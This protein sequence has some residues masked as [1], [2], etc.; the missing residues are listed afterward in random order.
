MPKT[1]LPIAN[2][3]YLSDSLPI[4]AQECV[5]WYPSLTEAPALS[6]ECLFGTPGLKQVATSGATNQANRGAHVMDGIPYFVNGG[7]LYRLNRTITND[8]ASYSTQAL[9][10][11][12]GTGRV[13]MADNGT[14]LC[15]VVGGTVSKGYIFTA[16]PDTLT[17]ISD[18]DFKANGEPQHVVFVDGYFA[19]TTNTKKFIIS[20]LN[21]GLQ[22]NALDFGSAEADPDPTVAPIVFNNQLFIGGTETIEG[23]QNVGGEGFPF[24]RTGLYLPKGISARF[25]IVNASNTFMFVGAG[26]NESPAIWAMS[27]N[28]VEKL[29]TIAIDS[30]LHKLTDAELQEVFAFSYAQR[31]AYFVCFALPNTMLCFDTISKRWHERKSQITDIF[32]ATNTIRF[33]A[34]SLAQAYGRV[35]VGDS[36]DGRIGDMSPEWYTEYSRNIKRSVATQ[37]FHNQG[38]AFF[39]PSVELTIESGVGNSAAPDPLIRMDISDDGGKTWSDERERRMGKVGEYSRRAIWRRNGRAA[40]FRVLRFS[41]SDPVKP[42]IIQ[43]AADIVGAQ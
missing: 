30:I 13:S 39:L 41:M 1:V 4:S 12:D 8:I 2:G 21:D 29:S 16:S 11:I 6:Q 34:N 37:P 14:Q 9:G 20:E 22:Y 42:V 15:I 5:N 38:D 35:F 28:A 43:L 26:R 10:T 36:Q 27:G 7:Q 31:G 40:R 19:F 24:Q 23:F 25:S 17:A 3:A 33:R 32:G 18:P